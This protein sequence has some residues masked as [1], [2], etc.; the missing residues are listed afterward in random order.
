MLAAWAQA[1]RDLVRMSPLEYEHGCRDEETERHGHAH[2]RRIG[3][4]Y[5]SSRED[6]ESFVSLHS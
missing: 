5:A 1:A 4:V 2:G 3:F 6:A